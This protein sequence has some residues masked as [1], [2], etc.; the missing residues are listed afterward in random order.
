[1]AET[2]PE[3][4]EPTEVPKD[5][6]ISLFNEAQMVRLGW[7]LPPRGSEA[8]AA[9]NRFQVAIFIGSFLPF[10]FVVLGRLYYIEKKSARGQAREVFLEGS[11]AR[12]VRFRNQ[13]RDLDSPPVTSAT[14]R[15]VAARVFPILD[16]GACTKSRGYVVRWE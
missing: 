2:A 8:S 4:R 3:E 6:R 14:P 15:D 11:R 9:M 7:S 1:L 5:Q 10:V 16:W 13:A 12:D